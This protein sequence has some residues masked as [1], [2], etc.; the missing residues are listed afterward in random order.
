LET[1]SH[2]LDFDNLDEAIADARK[3]GAEI[4]LDEAVE[5]ARGRP[6]STFEIADASGRVLAK[7]PFGG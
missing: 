6:N 1:D 5:D 7:V 2:G 3:A 4:L